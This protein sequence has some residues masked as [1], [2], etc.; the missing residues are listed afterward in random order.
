MK[1]VRAVVAIVDDDA[2]V[3]RALRRLVRSL[4]HDAATYESGEA[5][6]AGLDAVP[7]THI[8]LDLHMP[9]LHGPALVERVRARTRDARMIVMTGLEMAGVRDA[10][11]AAGADEFVR[12]PL[13]PAELRRILAA[14][15]PG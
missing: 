6:L 4:G 7:P 8:L 1:P 12:K 3:C 5:L 14:V 11:L 9:G 10:S 13:T 15:G 2:A